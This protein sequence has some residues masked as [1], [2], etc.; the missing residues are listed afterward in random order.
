MK[1]DDLDAR[2]ISGAGPRPSLTKQGQVLSTK[3]TNLSFIYM[4]LKK[5]NFPNIEIV[6]CLV[7]Q[8]CCRPKQPLS[9]VGLH[10]LV[11]LQISTFSSFMFSLFL[12]FRNKFFKN[13]PLIQFFAFQLFLA[14]S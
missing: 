9:I 5:I 12:L 13:I 7:M 2:V 8:I 14:N 11:V 6:I 4:L 10:W 3:T 1:A